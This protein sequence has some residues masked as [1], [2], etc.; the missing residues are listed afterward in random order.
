[1]CVAVTGSLSPL[2]SSPLLACKRAALG[3]GVTDE[4]LR[5]LAFVGCGLR[6][7][8]LTLSGE[9]LCLFVFCVACRSES[10]SRSVGLVAVIRNLSPLTH[11]FQT[12]RAVGR[13]DGRGAACALCCRPRKEFEV[14]G[15]WG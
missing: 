2:L 13:S 4:G 1:M 10:G 5:A 8:S 12:R 11:S 6:L 9:C 3:E 15:P 14:A 7:T